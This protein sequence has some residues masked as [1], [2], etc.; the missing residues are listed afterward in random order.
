MPCR[1]VRGAT[2]A[3]ENTQE[4]ILSA[5][6]RLL[7]LVIRENDI[8][9]ADVASI[10]FSMTGDLDAESPAVAA[11]QLGWNDVPL[12]CMRELDLSDSLPRCV[13]ILL[14]WN[15]DAPAAAIRHIY[16]N[17]AASL[18]PDRTPLLPINWPEVDAWIAERM[19]V[20]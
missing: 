2:T 7:A 18:R 13:R 14:H 3:D 20:A 16:I 8:Q 9:P 17:E 4:A 19:K 6:R 12:M 11:R 10:L 1:G 15:T 5:T